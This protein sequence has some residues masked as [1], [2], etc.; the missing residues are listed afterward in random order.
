MRNKFLLTVISFFFMTP[1]FAQ[2]VESMLADWER[3][4]VYTKAYLDAMP[5]DKYDLKPTPEMRSFAGQM[6]HITDANYG[7]SAMAAGTKSPI[8]FG[9]AEKTEDQSKENV[10]KLV[11]DG[12]DF[13]IDALKGMNPEALSEEIKVFGRFDLTKEQTF[14]KCFEHQTHHRGQTTVYLRLAGV[15][16]PPEQL[17]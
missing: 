5:A 3:A 2:S 4:K 13:V 8:G 15:T 9:E 10:T 7:F 1:I 17:F 6:L 16:P 14:I 12:Y 11:M